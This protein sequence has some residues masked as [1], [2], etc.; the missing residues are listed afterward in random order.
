ME[1]DESFLLKHLTYGLDM[2]RDPLQRVDDCIRGIAART[3]PPE[4]YVRA[5][6]A[7]LAS[8]EPLADELLVDSHSEA[9]VRAF[10][11][12]I[13]QRLAAEPSK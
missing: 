6:R 1:P 13:E 2:W 5:I 10:L 7:A 3:D 8:S 11:K 9:T 12:A 4:K